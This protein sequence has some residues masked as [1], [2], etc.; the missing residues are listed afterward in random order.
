MKGRNTGEKR[1]PINVSRTTAAI[2]A[3]KVDLTEWDDDEI[4]RGQRR[5][6]D[7]KFHGRPPQ[8]VAQAVHEERH[9]RFFM[10]GIELLKTNVVKA[11]DY[12]TRVVNDDSA[13]HSDR[14]KAATF[15]VERVYGKAPEHVTLDVGGEAPWMKAIMDSVVDLIPSADVIDVEPLDD[16]IPDEEPPEPEPPRAN[17]SSRRPRHLRDRIGPS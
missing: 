6:K 2:L 7:G 5:S 13:P 14:I 8:V 16:I 12:L 15:I 9:R 4:F 1:L 17:I 3:G 11:V 10:A